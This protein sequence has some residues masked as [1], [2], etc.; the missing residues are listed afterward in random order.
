MFS[1][2][3][4]LDRAA[5][6]GEITMAEPGTYG[7]SGDNLPSTLCV[8]T[9]RSTDKEATYVLKVGEAS[10]DATR[11]RAQNTASCTVRF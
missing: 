11:V 3:V 9:G 10:R 6:Q 7:A 8:Y 5:R 4:M 1:L 2:G